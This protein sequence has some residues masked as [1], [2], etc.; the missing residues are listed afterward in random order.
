MS[1]T[2]S[3]ATITLMVLGV[4]C[5]GGQPAEQAPAAGESETA[6][7][8]IAEQDFEDPQAMAFEEGGEEEEEAGEGEAQDP[9]PER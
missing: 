9:E 7:E 3:W 1:R 8:P 4:A 2:L 6:A 5:G